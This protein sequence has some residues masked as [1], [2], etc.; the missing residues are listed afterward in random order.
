MAGIPKAVLV[1]NEER[2]GRL[3]AR[4]RG[5][6]EANGHNLI[7]LD[8]SVIV[9]TGWLEPLVDVLQ[10]RKSIIVQPH[11]DKVNDPVTYEYVPIKE[12]MVAMLSWSLT[13]RMGKGHNSKESESIDFMESPVI[14]GAAFGVTKEYFES[15]GKLDAGV[16]DSGGENVELALR[17]WFCGGQIL[18]IPCSRVGV[19]NIHDPVKINSYP[20]IW[21][22]TEVWLQSHKEVV[23]SYFDHDLAENVGDDR[24]TAMVQRLT[25]VRDMTCPHNMAWFMENIAKDMF[26]PSPDVAKF[27]YLKV[28]TGSCIRLGPDNKMVLGTCRA[29][30]HKMLPAEMSFELMKDGQLRIKDKCIQCM[31][32]AYAVAQTCLGKEEQR[33]YWDYRDGKLINHWSKYCLMHVTDP[34][35][36]FKDDHRQILMAQPCDLDKT[37]KK[38]FSTYEFLKT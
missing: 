21:Y 32:N 6:R 24:K 26:A 20:A 1:R 10:D 18:V 14:H 37:D 5:A 34:D 16:G 33:Q 25:A 35:L 11:F 29:S 27:G 3:G 38:D 4:L 22:I 12:Q 19:L 36:K 13:V 23:K 7:F 8:T 9:S 17:T 28:K 2:Q 31:D 30:D 15:I